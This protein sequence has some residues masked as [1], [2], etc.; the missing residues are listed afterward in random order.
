MTVMEAAKAYL[1]GFPGLEELAL[2]DLGQDAGCACLWPIAGEPVMKTYLDGASKRQQSAY[3]WVRR[4]YGG[5]GETGR[6][7]NLAQWLE[8][9]SRAGNLPALDG[10]KRCWC[11]QVVDSPRVE[12]VQEDGLLVDQVTVQIIYFQEG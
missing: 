6:L 12:Q 11:V 5:A 4:G 9:Q 2:E 10:G 8:Q 7:E 1:Q 3:V